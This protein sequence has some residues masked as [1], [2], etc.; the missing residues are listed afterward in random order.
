[1][2]ATDMSPEIARQLAEASTGARAVP[3][4]FRIEGHDRVTTLILDWDG[5]PG[6]F[7]LSE[8][9][10][11]RVGPF[12][13]YDA[14]FEGAA[15]AFASG[16]TQET[17]MTPATVRVG[18]LIRVTNPEAFQAEM[19]CSTGAGVGP[20]DLERGMV[21]LPVE[22]DL[23]GI[24][25]ILVRDLS[26]GEDQMYFEVEA[27]VSDMGRLV[28]AAREAYL[29]AW[30]D[31]TWIPTSPQEALFELALGSNANPSPDQLG[32]EILDHPLTRGQV[33]CAIEA[34]LEVQQNPILVP[35]APLP[36][37]DWLELT[38]RDDSFVGDGR[39]VPGTRDLYM[40][41]LRALPRPDRSGPEPD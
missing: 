17:L 12:G 40:A 7:D 35:D 16:L 21:R 22:P 38:G 20:S 23:A 8:R 39:A 24:D 3:E 34:D 10:E 30:W 15:E 41:A 6:G 36:Y 4:K 1:M 5:C 29:E 13:D 19:G 26:V 9:V 31:N 11:I 2:N 32:F 25:R 27:E 18:V 14:R 33:R 28:R 37:A